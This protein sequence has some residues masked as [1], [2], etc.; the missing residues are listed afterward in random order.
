MHEV[1][2]P[3]RPASGVAAYGS[4]H[5]LIYMVSHNNCLSF[6]LIDYTILFFSENVYSSLLL[7]IGV[8]T[9]IP[10]CFSA[11]YYIRC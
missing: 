6:S 7:Y 10:P 4:Q 5:L 2:V 3:L 9:D 8:L 1:G 11:S